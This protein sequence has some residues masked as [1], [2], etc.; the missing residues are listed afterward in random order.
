MNKLNQY[1]LLAVIVPILCL[2][3]GGWVVWN[4]VKR[5][6]AAN[7]EK[8]VVEKNLA[9]QKK[10]VADIGSQPLAAKEPTAPM[11]EAEQAQ[12]L[13]SLRTIAKQSGVTLTRWSN[14]PA[15]PQDPNKPGA[16]PKDVSAMISTLEV[17]G[18]Y[19]N[20]REFLYSIARAPR[21]LNFSGIRWGRSGNGTVLSV[22]VTRYVSTGIAPAPDPS[23]S[24][25]TGAA[26]QSL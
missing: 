2:A 16:L 25:S 14:V 22:T 11:S 23:K 1:R 21:L 13:E 3:V 5:L 7:V 15:P 26:E 4:Q 12:F 6:N 17:N 18:G 8:A 24:V 10:M 20:V 19:G 9:F